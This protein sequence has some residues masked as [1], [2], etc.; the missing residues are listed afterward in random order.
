[1]AENAKTCEILVTKKVRRRSRGKVEW[2]E[3]DK[4]IQRHTHTHKTIYCNDDD[5][6][7][8]QKTGRN[9]SND[10]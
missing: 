5:E 4:D 10:V 2:S 1:M 3:T 9:K 6:W 8:A 7:F